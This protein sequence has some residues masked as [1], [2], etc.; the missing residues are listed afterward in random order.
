MKILSIETSCDET[1]VCLLE[2]TGDFDADFSYKVLGNAL[3][4]QAHL[5]AQYGGVFPNLA[6]REHAKNLVP[7]L[8]EALRQASALSA[9]AAQSLQGVPLESLQA[10]L[11]REPELLE[12]I[13]PFIESYQK[14]D[15]DAIAV[16]YGPGLEPALWVGIN[17]AKALSYV[18]NVPLVPVNHME[19]HVM[20]S[21]V[22]NGAMR[23]FEFP[24]L[25]LLIS[26]GHT[27]LILSREWMKYERIG[28][29]RD[30]AAGEAFDKVARLM[31][32]PYPGGP[33]I[34]QLAAEARLQG[35]PL[36]LKFTPPMLNSKDY[37]FSFSGLKTEVRKV[38]EAAQP[39]TDDKKKEIALAFENA[40]AHVLVHK[41]IKAVEEFDVHTV[42]VGGG[43]S[44]NSFIRSELAAKLAQRDA[45]ASLLVPAPEF[46]TDNALM[47][48]IA[49]YFHA[50]RKDFAQPE[51]ISATGNLRLE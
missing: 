50:L 33:V 51:A 45:S 38:V 19:G 25:S 4:S 14:P 46:A 8:E 48:A 12:K 20:M 1:A 22:Q 30:D 32:L 18:W 49:G 15:I 10:S 27:E 9:S 47:I 2:A 31:E 42:V 29:T 28:E 6:K 13:I 36:E 44:A 34:S 40:V 35:V 37:D 43:V 17:F 3:F 5:H 11:A 39:L 23:G 41:T 16:T 24:V 21:M 7:L 26:G